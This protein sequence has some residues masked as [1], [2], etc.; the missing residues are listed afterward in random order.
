MCVYECVSSQADVHVF[1]QR[2]MAVQS[3]CSHG[4]HT[5]ISNADK[6]HHRDASSR[7][8]QPQIICSVETN[9]CSSYQIWL[10]L[11]MKLIERRS[12]HNTTH[13]FVSDLGKMESGEVLTLCSVG[14]LES[15]SHW[16]G[17]TVEMFAVM[18][19]STPFTVWKRINTCHEKI[20]QPLWSKLLFV[21]TQQQLYHIQIQ[22]IQSRLTEQQTLK[23]CFR[24]LST[25]MWGG[26]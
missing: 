21:S 16:W 1:A 11:Q 20:Y 7:R 17:C 14:L 6:I 3:A 24:R 4:S 15:S 22:A 23:G 10:T 19:A 8:R 5:G 25:A 12:L 2:Q 26:Y 18:S 9:Q 13:Y